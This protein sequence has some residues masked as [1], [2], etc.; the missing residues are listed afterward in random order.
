[1]RDGIGMTDPT[2]PAPGQWMIIK[3]ATGV[4]K[5]FANEPVSSQ[6]VHHSHRILPYKHLRCFAYSIACPEVYVHVEKP[7]K[8]RRG[9]QS[10]AGASPSVT[11]L[12]ASGAETGTWAPGKTE[13]TLT[14]HRYPANCADTV[15]NG[16]GRL[17][18]PSPFRSSERTR[19]GRHDC[20]RCRPSAQ[21]RNHHTLGRSQ[22]SRGRR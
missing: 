13:R 3:V 5:L 10:D 11:D 4:E 20:G 22:F 19:H 12:E 16:C 9:A 6:T 15:V 18:L 8:I 7:E 17:L 1:M 21:C 2:T 14:H